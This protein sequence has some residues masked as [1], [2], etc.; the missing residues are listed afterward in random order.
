MVPREGNHSHSRI[1]MWRGPCID[2]PWMMKRLPLSTRHI[3]AHPRRRLQTLLRTKERAINLLINS[4]PV[5][6]TT[7]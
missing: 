5:N 7:L 3:V 2:K 4:K 6:S 1:F